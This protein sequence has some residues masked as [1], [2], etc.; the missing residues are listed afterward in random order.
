MKPPAIVVGTA[1]V[2][3]GNQAVAWAA[4][5]A[6]SRH[7]PLRIVH[8]LEWNTD[9]A[10]E[11]DGSSYVERVW[12]SSTA[13]TFAAARH[14][15]SIAPGV[16]V[17]AD[18]LIGQPGELLPGLGRDAALL[19]VGYHGGGGFAGL[20]LGS[21]GQRVATHA[22]CPVVIVRGAPRTGGP[23]V[24]G[25]DDSPAADQVLEAAF[26]AAATRATSLVVV[27]SYAPAM[28]LWVA[29][30]RPADVATPE[31]DAAA[32]AAVEE[33]LAPWRSKFPEVPAEVR[34]IH[35]AISPVLTGASAEA[36]LVVV[37]SHGRGP[38][39]GALLGSTGLHLLRHAECPVL[40]ARGHN[41]S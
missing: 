15:Q 27:R 11:A 26:I 19:V 31:Q 10:R 29:G 37:G 40:V 41:G 1:G 21:V 17:T 36:Q 25:V 22:A 32:G 16:D 38:I 18:T 6:E 5:E 35:D 39:R 7:L 24:A 13:L 28:Q 8:V 14:A 4:R 33:Q 34:L 23:V 20:R 3:S 12:S 2:D 30:V 9:E